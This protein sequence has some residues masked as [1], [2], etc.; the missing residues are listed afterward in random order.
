MDGFGQNRRRMPL[1][2]AVVGSL[3][4]HQLQGKPTEQFLRFEFPLSAS[5]RSKLSTGTYTDL[6]FK[7]LLNV[8]TGAGPWLL[9]R[10]WVGDSASGG[11]G[12][13]GSGGAGGS[14]GTGGVSGAG[15]TSGNAGSAGSSDRDVTFRIVTP[16]GVLPADVAVG[17]A[18]SLRLNDRVS[19]KLA[20][21]AG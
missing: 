9:D 7:I 13:G 4:E 18:N 17:A 1:A 15:G 12:T 11:G 10:L 14:G 8:A 3:A 5:T 16:K 20:N 6:R 19:L 2:A 21:G